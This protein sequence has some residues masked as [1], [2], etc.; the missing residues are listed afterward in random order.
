[1]EAIVSSVLGKLAEYTVEPVLRQFG[2]LIHYESN[3][4]RLNN[5]VERL[6]AQRRDVAEKIEAATRNS[7]TI[8]H[9]VEIW[10]DQVDRTLRDKDTCF[11]NERT[12]KAECCSNGWFPNLKIRH[13]LSRKAKKMTP[14]V[15]SLIDNK[16]EVVGF[17]ARHEG[18]SSSQASNIMNF[19]SRK[20]IIE[21]VMEALKGNQVN[22][23]VI[24][25]MGGIGK[26]TMV[27]EVVIRAKK[28]GLVDEHAKVVVNDKPDI[29]KIQ[30]DIAELLG[31]KLEEQVLE[32]RAD[33]LFNRLS[34]KR[35]LVVLDNVWETLDLREIGIPS[36]LN[37]CKIL[38]TSRNQDIFN[39]MEEARKKFPID[40]LPESD[41][42]SLFKKMAGDD[43][44]SDPELRSIAEQ[45]LEKCDG[46]PVAISTLGSALRGKPRASWNYALGLLQNP[47]EGDIQP[48]E[49][50][51][52]GMKKNVYHPIRLSYDFLESE[53]VKSLFLLCCIFR[54]S[55]DIP[56][57]DLVTHAFGLRVFQ[58]IDKVEKAR[59][60]V[61]AL[62]YTLKSCYLLLDS[63]KEECVRMH[64]VVRAV[65][66]RIASD[67]SEG[68][69]LVRH[70]VPLENWSRGYIC[71]S[72]TANK[73]THELLLLSRTNDE[74][75]S[76]VGT[77]GTLNGVEDLKVLDISVPYKGLY[78]W[79]TFAIM[80]R[81]RLESLPILMRNI[82]TLCLRGLEL[83][84]ETISMIGDL[85]TLTI[86]R[87]G[88][89]SIQYVPEEFKN[90]CNLKL[91]DL[92]DC[93]ELQEISSGVIS[94]LTKLEELY[95]W[96]VFVDEFRNHSVC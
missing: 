77:L 58:R 67:E 63:G 83:R 41:A 20:S 55:T 34:A 96:V 65:G 31:L 70:G 11:E 1:M 43:I 28:E 61:E 49:G 26:T 88:G 89:S 62:V 12:A 87:L 84:L 81:T 24:C 76:N 36:G 60:G 47:F 25:G 27:K 56:V 42:W 66:L 13:S 79:I 95:L 19:E 18:A 59:D 10:L 8:L 48:F 86:L 50:E 90:L 16:F 80:S 21:G 4:A 17:A 14:D 44:E 52:Q 2:Y 71:T 37:S 69:F 38:V 7:E 23:I 5:Q 33:K 53:R 92:A 45:V 6:N 32:S 54:E 78:T 30:S 93:S 72:L 57:E 82:Q 64:D 75:R 94:S 68:T 22:L 91:L 39:D 9:Q 51:I 29:S 40:V 74:E 85:R 15:D 3:V 35:V 73:S 46:L